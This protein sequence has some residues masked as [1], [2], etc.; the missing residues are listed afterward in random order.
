MK[1]DGVNIKVEACSMIDYYAGLPHMEL[2]GYFNFYEVDSGAPR[3]SAGR[4]HQ[5][6]DEIKLIAETHEEINLAYSALDWIESHLSCWES[7]NWNTSSRGR[8]EDFM[9]RSQSEGE[10]DSE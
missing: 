9:R 5:D 3:G 8:A 7:M 2:V 6:C 4:Y 10:S 1:V